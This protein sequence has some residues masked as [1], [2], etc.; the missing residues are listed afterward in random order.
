MMKMTQMTMTESKLRRIAR[1][2]IEVIVTLVLGW[3]ALTAWLH[4]AYIFR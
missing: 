3:Y 4:V 1:N 2:I